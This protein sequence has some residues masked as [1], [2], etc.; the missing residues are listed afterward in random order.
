MDDRIIPEEYL[1]PITKDVMEDP[2]CS[3]DGHTYERIAIIQHLEHEGKSPMTRQE[4]SE[5]QLMP[6]RVLKSIIDKWRTEKQ[7]IEVVQEEATNE[8]QEAMNEDIYFDVETKLFKYKN[9]NELVSSE[10]VFVVLERSKC[11]GS[12]KYKGSVKEG[13]PHGKGILYNENGKKI[14]ESEYSE[15][16][17]HG[18]GIRFDENGKKS[19]EGD[20][21]E[22]RPHGKGI[23]YYDNGKKAYEGDFSQGK[24]HGNGIYYDK[25][26]G[27]KAYEGDYS[28]GKRH[29]K[30]IEFK[31]DRYG[32]HYKS[33][34]GDYSEGK[35]HGK[36]IEFDEETGHYKLYEGDYSEGQRHGKGVHY[37]HDKEG[38]KRYEGHF[39]QDKYHGNGIYYFKN[40]TKQY[41]GNWSQNKW[42]GNGVEYYG[43]NNNNKKKKEG[44]WSQGKFKSGTFFDKEG[45]EFLSKDL[46]KLQ[47]FTTL[48]NVHRRTS[49]RTRKTI[50]VT[51]P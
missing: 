38:Y 5:G 48:L 41:E 19:Y 46:H 42:H 44:L 3:P 16:I 1:C 30:G 11:K 14:Y 40:N 43:K 37:Y 29:G 6:N 36:G 45:I 12:V 27:K 8:S 24:L 2:V 49:K 15:G 20:Y 34:E 35:R 7:T 31:H 4:M 28:E 18:K 26:T 51:K 10:L 9:T 17:A 23:L 47:K 25:Q 32:H 21:S 39:F 50:K 33:Y 13:K 22:G